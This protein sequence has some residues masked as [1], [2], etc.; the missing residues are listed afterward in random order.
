MERI[1][2]ERKILEDGQHKGVITGVESREK[3]FKY[4]DLIIESEG[5]SLKVGYPDKIMK[6]SKLGE[7]MQAFGANLEVGKPINIEST[8]IGR[9]CTF[10]TIKKGIYANIV[11]ESVKPTPTVKE[12]HGDK[13]E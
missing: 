10:V 1:V 4:I 2:E 5:V 3:P 6:E 9:G 12:M 11:P 7:L 8:F 13:D